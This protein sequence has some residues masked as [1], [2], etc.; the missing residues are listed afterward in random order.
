MKKS[1][2]LR[3]T[4]L[5]CMVLLGVSTDGVQAKQSKGIRISF[6]N[7]SSKKTIYRGTS[8]KFKVKI[9]PSRYKKKKLQWSS[10][11][12]SVA[13]VNSKGLVS[14]KKNGT[15]YITVKMKGHKSKKVRCKVTVKTKKVQ[16]ISFDEKKVVMRQ[17]QCFL[18][19]VRITPSNAFNRKVIYKSSD[20]R[21]AAVNDHGKIYAKQQG[22]AKIT[23]FSADGSRK[24]SDCTVK[25]IGKITKNSTKFIAH[26]GLSS[27]APENTVKAFKLAGSSGF[28]GAET[29]IR[30]TRDK[31][32]IAIHDSTLKRMCGIN[33]RPEDMSYKDI[34]KLKIKNGNNIEKY[35]RDRSATR[36]ASL[37]EYLN[38]CKASD[39]VPVIE[40][41]M[42][43]SK[44]R[45]PVKSMGKMQTAVKN[46]LEELEL[47]V[48]KIMGDHPYMYIAFDSEAIEQMRDIVEEMDYADHVSFQ[49]ITKYPTITKLNYYKKN[50]F[51]LDCSYKNLSNFVMQ[52][53]QQAE[54]PVNIWTVD[55]AETA[56]G[57]LTKDID[58]ITTNKKFW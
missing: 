23:A 44:K 25:V 45:G 53:F 30:M 5:L 37:E 34:R 26:R 38:V 46:D 56:W 18:E 35:K 33:K 36:I 40:I 8:K 19:K 7:V 47:Q 10:S 12:R 2:F 29:D 31:R 58:Y 21:V 50:G 41:K 27:I 24:K 15:A 28:W 13:V 39:M 51:G 14:A 48:H 57:F 42:E 32:F 1:R 11:N 43:Y 16:R 4:L 6:S 49:H 17:G 22:S 3:Y 54:V 55:E 52:G 20:S 9:S